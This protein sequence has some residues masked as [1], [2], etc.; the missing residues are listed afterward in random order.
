MKEMA[1][2]SGNAQDREQAAHYQQNLALPET[3][4]SDTAVLEINANKAAMWLLNQKSLV[5]NLKLLKKRHLE[6]YAVGVIRQAPAL[7]KN[8]DQDCIEIPFLEQKDRHRT[9]QL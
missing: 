2:L 1:E 9:T 5:Q 6:H 8:Q 4:L 7:V 3:N